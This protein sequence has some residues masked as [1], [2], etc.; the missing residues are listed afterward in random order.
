VI[1]KWVLRTVGLWA[2]KRG[3][4]WW[5]NRRAEEGMSPTGEES[6]PGEGSGA[7]DGE[8]ED[9]GRSRGRRGR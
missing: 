6:Y 5:Q 4:R 3:Y 2:A 8:N 1:M 7:P 9:A